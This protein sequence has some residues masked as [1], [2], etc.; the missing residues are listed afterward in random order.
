[1]TTDQRITRGLPFEETETGAGIP[2]TEPCIVN[3]CPPHRENDCPGCPGLGEVMY[4]IDCLVKD[5]R[6][7]EASVVWTRYELSG[8]LPEY[9]QMLMRTDI[10]SGLAGR[11]QDNPV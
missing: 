9:E 5:I 7:L 10:V 6:E 4:L 11:Y 8:H 1:M 2:V 3:G